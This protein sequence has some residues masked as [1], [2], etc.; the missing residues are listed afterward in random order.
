MTHHLNHTR[1][2]A[3]A[4]DTFWLPID[5]KTPRNVK[6]LAIAREASGVAQQAEIPTHNTWWTHW[7]PLPR[8][9]PDTWAPYDAE[10]DGK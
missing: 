2:A 1:T 7:H 10:D 5:A 9:R 8:F 4:Q 3:V 6:C